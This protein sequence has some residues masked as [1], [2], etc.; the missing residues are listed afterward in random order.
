MSIPEMRYTLCFLFRDDAI[1]MLKRNHAPNRGLWN[2]VGGK[3]GRGETPVAACLREVREETGYHLITLRFHGILTWEGYETPSG[4]L[5]IFSAPAP[6]GEPHPTPEGE[7]RWHPKTWVFS[8]PEVVSNIHI[9]GP[10]LD[11][12]CAP[13]WWHFRYHEGVIASWQERPLPMWVAL[14]GRRGCCSAPK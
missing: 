4:G 6:E 2:G 5:Y 14:G 12:G 13:R 11:A 10:C 7:L 3:I 8:S 1:L 9:F